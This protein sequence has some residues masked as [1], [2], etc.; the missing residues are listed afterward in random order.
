MKHM[1]SSA[2]QPICTSPSSV[3]MIVEVT[4]SIYGKVNC[5]DCLRRVIAESE[6]RTRVLRELLENME[7]S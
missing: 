6:V 4:R 1:K 2:D 3:D 7:V 5:T